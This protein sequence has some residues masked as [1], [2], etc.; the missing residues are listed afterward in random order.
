MASLLATGS[1]TP[2]IDFAESQRVK[3]FALLIAELYHI[4]LYGNCFAVKKDLRR[5]GEIDSE[6]G[7]RA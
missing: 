7:L 1:S 3:P 5:Y 4:P 6:I 2:V